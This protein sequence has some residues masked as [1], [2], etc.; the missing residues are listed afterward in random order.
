MVSANAPCRKA[1]VT[2]S[3]QKCNLPVHEYQQKHPLRIIHTLT[4]LESPER[5]PKSKAAN[6]VESRQIKPQHHIGTLLPRRVHA[7]SR[8]QIIHDLAQQ[9][10][11]ILQRPIGERVR[12][13]LAHFPMR[14][15]IPLANDR[16]RLVGERAAIIKGALDKGPMALPEPVNVFPGTGGAEGDF[17]GGRPHH[18]AVLFVQAEQ[19]VGLATAQEPVRVRDVA[20]GGEGGA[21]KAIERVLDMFPEDC[22]DDDDGGGGGEAQELRR[23]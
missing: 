1:F 4:Q 3:T 15:R 10:L 22:D 19:G 9:S 11:L 13:I 8:N 23:R 16:M 2:R 7:Q 6:D 18:W 14:N 12:E 21:G 20:P 5:L 17:V